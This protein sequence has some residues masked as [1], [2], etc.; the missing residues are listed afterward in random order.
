[1][2]TPPHE[3]DSSQR[4]ATF[5]EFWLF[6][7]R[8]HS[9]PATRAWHFVG[10]T[11]ALGL[12]GWAIAQRQWWLLAAVPLAGYGLAWFSHFAIQGNRPA[13]FRYPLWS[14]RADGRM[15]LLMLTGRMGQE[16]RRLG[17]GD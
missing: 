3:S 9:R 1:M 15:W 8:E 13:T 16:V 12:L 5:D 6:Y 10:T 17:I 2:P 14:L 7:V 11:L 4:I